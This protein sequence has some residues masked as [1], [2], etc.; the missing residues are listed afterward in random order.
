METSKPDGSALFVLSRQ[1]PQQKLD[2]VAI[3]AELT[4]LESGGAAL[5]ILFE[6]SQISAWPFEAPSAAAILEWNASA[7][8]I[9]RAA[10]VHDHKLTRHAALLAALMRVADAQVRSFH[11]RDLSAAVA[12]LEQGP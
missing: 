10:I 7:L 1:G 6:W 5:L 3:A 12:W 8:S 11:P 9:A 4:R 2:I